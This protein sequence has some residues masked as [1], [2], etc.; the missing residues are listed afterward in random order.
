M[1]HF[2]Q[3]VKFQMCPHGSNRGKRAVAWQLQSRPGKPARNCNWFAQVCPA[4]ETRLM[5][6]RPNP[7]ASAAISLDFK[8]KWA[9]PQFSSSDWLS[10]P[11]MPTSDSNWCKCWDASCRQPPAWTVIMNQVCQWLLTH[12]CCYV[13]ASWSLNGNVELLQQHIQAK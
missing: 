6:L 9:G 13:A 10:E 3:P 4:W 1:G 2:L 8:A 7:I 5:R 11:T 12:F